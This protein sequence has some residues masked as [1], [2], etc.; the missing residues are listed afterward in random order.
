MCFERFPK[1]DEY[2]ESDA[3]SLKDMKKHPLDLLR[4][5]ERKLK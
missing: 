5:L 4:V 2:L 1:M 3:F